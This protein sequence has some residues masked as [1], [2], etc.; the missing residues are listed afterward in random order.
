MFKKKY[1]IVIKDLD[2]TIIL[3]LIIPLIN[4]FGSFWSVSSHS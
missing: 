3:E 4:L 2:L 1:W